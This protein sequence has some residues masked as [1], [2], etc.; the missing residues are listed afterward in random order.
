MFAYGRPLSLI[1]V[2]LALKNGIFVDSQ[3]VGPGVNTTPDLTEQIMPQRT[4]PSLLSRLPNSFGRLLPANQLPEPLPNIP[5]NCPEIPNLTITQ[6]TF[7]PLYKDSAGLSSLNPRIEPSKLGLNTPFKAPINTLCAPNTVP[8][9]NIAPL[10]VI[11]Q[12]VLDRPANLVPICES[13]YPASIPPQIECL[14]VIDEPN[15]YVTQTLQVKSYG[16]SPLAHSYQTPIIVKV[17]PIPVVSPSI[18]VAN[19]YGA[20]SSHNVVQE[21]CDCN[22]FGELYQQ[23]L[24]TEVRV[25]SVP[26]ETVVDLSNDVSYYGQVPISSQVNVASQWIPEPV[27][28]I[29]PPPQPPSSVSSQVPFPLFAPPPIIVLEKSKS[30]LKTLL[31]ILLV[32]LLDGGGRNNGGCSSSC[33]SV[34]PMPFPILIPTSNGCPQSSGQEGNDMEG[35]GANG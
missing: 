5:R 24:N 23:V 35:S 19:P 30:S 20:L 11:S 27:T 25:S 33:G 13:N 34:I 29:A 32:S 16:T 4:P 7:H 18:V 10:P 28:L 12:P 8:Q 31:P 22:T 21:N 26:S 9:H 14:T 2:F 15:P 6:A 3:M 1:F 17:P